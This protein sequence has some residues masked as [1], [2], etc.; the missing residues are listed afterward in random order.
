MIYYYSKKDL[1]MKKVS[2]KYYILTLVLSLSLFSTLGFTGAIKF[3]RFVEKIPIIIRP[4]TDESCNVKNI[5]AEINNLN[6]EHKDIVFQQIMLETNGLTSHV[7]KAN[8]NLFGMKMAYSRQKL[9][10]G[11]QFN[12]CKYDNWKFSLYDYSLFQ[13]RYGSNLTKEQYYQFLKEAGYS[14]SSNYIEILKKIPVPKEL[15]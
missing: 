11:E 7:F 6:L 15:Q 1:M 9:Q 13:A 14:E 10:Q 3:N 2:V 4:V 8:H 12:H 5:I